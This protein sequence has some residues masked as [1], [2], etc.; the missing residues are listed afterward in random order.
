MRGRLYDPIVARFTSADP[1]VQAPYSS[2]SLN[3]YSYVWNNPVNLTDPSGFESTANNSELVFEGAGETSSS[4]G[5]AYQPTG[6]MAGY[7]SY[8]GEGVFQY[9]SYGPQQSYSYTAASM[10]PSYEPGWNASPAAEAMQPMAIV[11]PNPSASGSGD[12][13]AASSAN[14]DWSPAAENEARAAGAKAAVMDWLGSNALL[15]SVQ[16]GPPAWAAA[17]YASKALSDAAPAAPSDP[18]L[19]AAY[20]DT[21]EGVSTLAMALPGGKSVGTAAARGLARGAENIRRFGSLNEAR[22]AARQ[23]AGLGDDA[24]KYVS[25][26]GPMRGQVVGSASRDGLRGWR[27]DF[28]QT[29]G[30]HVNWWNRTAGSARSDWIYGANIVEGGNEKAFLE[31]LQHFQ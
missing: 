28:D 7:S 4:G 26:V 11:P 22:A 27:I 15:G 29:K 8:G 1:I 3:R 19:A 10:E 5:W 24:V 25:E 21:Y 30:F 20:N 12:T 16:F 23:M 2:Q 14:S 31:L 17:W 18:R 13:S 9:D 6:G